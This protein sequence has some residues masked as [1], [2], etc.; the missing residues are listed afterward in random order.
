MRLRTIATSAR[1]ILAVAFLLLGTAAAGGDETDIAR[2]LK[3]LGAEITQT[4]GVVNG[5]SFRDCSKLGDSEFRLIGK[6]PHLKKLVVYGGCKGLNDKTL[7]HLTGLA[8]LEE[9][10][11]DQ[12]QVS[13]DGLKQLTALK[14]LR[15]LSFFHVSFGSK[16]F[17][18]T[19]LAHVK[20]LSK[21]ERLTIAGTPFNDQGMEALGQL[22]Q[23]KEVGTWHTGQTAA[24][25]DHLKGLKNLTRL[26]MGQRLYDGKPSLT[27]ETM[28]VLTE[29]KSLESLQLDEARLTGAALAKLKALP[30]LKRL[31]LHVIDIPEAEVEALRGQL[32][33][34][35]VKWDK[36]D[37]KGMKYIRRFFDPR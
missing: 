12:I 21:L 10:H 1:A 32:T 2:E 14:E 19:G 31:T 8:T 13:D 22:T 24:G 30:K 6:L 25:M 37:D 26:H 27:D 23:L 4:K 15:A 18:G 17:T 16:T 7:A 5:V 35:E 34:V 33:S 3:E 36:P 9:L 29:L 28:A 20:E 11:T